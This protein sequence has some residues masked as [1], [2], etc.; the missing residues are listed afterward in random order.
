MSAHSV[1]YHPI[2]SSCGE[3]LT[4]PAPVDKPKHTLSAL[5]PPD[6]HEISLFRMGL[7]LIFF[8]VTF[9]SMGV[10]MVEL[11]T[12][13]ESELNQVEAAVPVMMQHA[14]ILSCFQ[15]HTHVDGIKFCLLNQLPV[16]ASPIST[17]IS[18]ISDPSQANTEPLPMLQ[19]PL[20][21]PLS[22]SSSHDSVSSNEKQK[23]E[24]RRHADGSE[25]CKYQ[26]LCYDPVT[27]TFV[28]DDASEQAAQLR[29][30]FKIDWR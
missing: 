1:S 23:V 27:S 19:P 24:C 22:S 18:T 20:L 29:N 17:S 9:V 5:F 2:N 14:D 8:S 4:D 12:K 30:G 15:Q 6:K 3:D 13:R 25:V 11:V 7:C 10:T 26:H 28:L 16:P 21:P